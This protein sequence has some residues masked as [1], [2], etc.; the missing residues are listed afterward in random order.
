MQDRLIQSGM[1]LIHE[2]KVIFTKMAL[3][4]KKYLDPSSVLDAVLDDQGEKLAIGDERDI[5]EYN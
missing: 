5:S 1:K 2:L 3:G 4:K